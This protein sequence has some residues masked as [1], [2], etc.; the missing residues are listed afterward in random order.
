MN[1]GKVQDSKVTTFFKPQQH[2]QWVDTTTTGGGDI[3]GPTLSERIAQRVQ[4]D[5]QTSKT[6]TPSQ[7]SVRLYSHESS[8]RCQQQRMI[9]VVGGGGTVGHTQGEGGLLVTPPKE[10]RMCVDTVSEPKS[11]KTGLND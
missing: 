6:E 9:C 3:F 1:P 2:Q 5:E 11:G 4:T 10:G 7:H 8:K